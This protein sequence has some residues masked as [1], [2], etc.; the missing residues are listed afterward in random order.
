[1]TALHLCAATD[2]TECMKLLLKAGADVAV[3]DGSGR[4]PLQ[5]ARQL[6]HHSCQELVRKHFCEFVQKY[7]PYLDGLCG[8]VRGTNIRIFVRRDEYLHSWVNKAGNIVC[9]F[10]NKSLL[11]TALR[12]CATT[13]RSVC[14]GT[15]NI[16]GLG[17]YDAVHFTKSVQCI[18]T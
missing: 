14:I 7:F 3:K 16:E 18:L 15:L 11:R 13:D 12:L 2:R 10:V 17:R 9:V 8:T 4:T 5:L 6:G 1:M